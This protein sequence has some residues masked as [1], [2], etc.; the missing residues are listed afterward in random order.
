MLL[1]SEFLVLQ[2]LA[3]SGNA[4]VLARTAPAYDI[5]GFDVPA[6]DVFDIT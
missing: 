6:A 1:V 4:K 5:D 2:T 3:K